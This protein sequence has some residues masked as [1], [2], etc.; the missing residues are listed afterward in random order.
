MLSVL[1]ALS[2]IALIAEKVGPIEA[3]KRSYRIVLKDVWGFVLSSVAVAIVISI[4]NAI[5]VVGW[6]ANVFSPI[7]FMLFATTFYRKNSR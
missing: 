2:P 4:L 3:M 6:L 5:P 7:Y 1:L